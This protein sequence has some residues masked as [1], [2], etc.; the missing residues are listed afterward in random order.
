MSKIKRELF[1][2]IENLKNV[3]DITKPDRQSLGNLYK[4]DNNYKEH[5][6]SFHF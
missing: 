5:R 1:K 6:S 4:S 2:E 3:N